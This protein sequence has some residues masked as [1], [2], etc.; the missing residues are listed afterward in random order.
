MCEM[1]SSGQTTVIVLMNSQLLV[2]LPEQNQDFHN[3]STDR[4]GIHKTRP[5][6]KG[7][8]LGPGEEVKSSLREEV[9]DI[10]LG[11]SEVSGKGEMGS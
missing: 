2:W 3:F 8:F 11:T 6:S 10:E 9:V 5:L 7:Q 1:T 4:E